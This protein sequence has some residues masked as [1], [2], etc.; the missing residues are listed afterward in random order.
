MVAGG[1]H[2]LDGEGDV[3]GLA[4]TVGENVTDAEGEVDPDGVTDPVAEGENVGLAVLLTVTDRVR[5][6]WSKQHDTGHAG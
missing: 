2:H 6:A 1:K 3:D 4:E 5:E